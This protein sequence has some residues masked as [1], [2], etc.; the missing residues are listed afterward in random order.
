M[1][2]IKN[3]TFILMLLSTGASASAQTIRILYVS[4]KIDYCPGV[5]DP[6][7]CL[8]VREDTC[9]EW[10]YYP[11]SIKGFK[12]QEGT[13]Y[14]LLVKADEI[15]NPYNDPAAVEYKLVRTLKKE[16]PHASSNIQNSAV[17]AAGAPLRTTGLSGAWKLTELNSRPIGDSSRISIRFADSNR[18]GGDSGCNHYGGS[19]TPNNDSIH[20]SM[21]PMTR[22]ACYPNEIMKLESEYLQTLRKAVAFKKDAALLV[23][24]SADGN[25]IA[26]FTPSSK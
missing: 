25:E 8:L 15:N 18:F 12:Y 22:M 17:S 3:I 1:L 14:I 11:F 21:G 26:K 19:Y 20:F 7:K 2:L 5:G 23:I 9:L 13:S 10:T 6:H 4:D 24:L 16:T